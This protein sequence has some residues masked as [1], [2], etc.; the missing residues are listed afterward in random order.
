MVG[1]HQRFVRGARQFLD[2]K[3]GVARIGVDP[4][5]DR[6]CAEIDLP[7]QRCGFLQPRLVFL[8][9]REEGVEFLPER[10]RHCVLQLRAADLQDIAEFD[11]L[12]LE[13]K[14]E[15]IQGFDQRRRGEDDGEPQRRRDR[16]RSSI[17]TC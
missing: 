13:R 7:E 1:R 8:D 15:F 10:H 14:G 12:G 4:G 16:R 5:A 9:R 3:R 11:C 2:R 6:G 17:A